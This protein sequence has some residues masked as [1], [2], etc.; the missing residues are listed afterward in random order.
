MDVL[1]CFKCSWNGVV[2]LPLKG[3]H[4]WYNLRTLSTYFILRKCL[5]LHGRQHGI[6]EIVRLRNQTDWGLK[7][8]A[9][10][11]SSVPLAS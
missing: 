5:S 6:V 10:V 4:T 9:S 8:L 1:V 11:A 2:A 3:A 7:P